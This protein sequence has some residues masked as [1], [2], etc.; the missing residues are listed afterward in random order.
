MDWVRTDTFAK[1]IT[2][3]KAPYLARLQWWR[4]PKQ[5]WPI[6]LS[7]CVK[8]KGL[9]GLLP[10]LSRKHHRDEGHG[11]KS[12]DHVTQ[13]YCWW[14]FDRQYAIF[15]R[16]ANHKKALMIQVWGQMNKST[17]SLSTWLDTDQWLH[18]CKNNGWP[19]APSISEWSRRFHK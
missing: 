11:P 14:S 18:N 12:I 7:D 9:T 17:A 6:L 3:Y 16:S 13:L 8:G 15:S 2:L 19:R 10:M 4:G 5:R 1:L